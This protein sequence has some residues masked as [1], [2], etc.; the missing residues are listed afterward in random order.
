MR[1]V[2]WRTRYYEPQLGIFSALD[3]FEGKSCTPMS[4]NG[5]GYVHCNPINMVDP[6]GAIALN[7]DMSG[8]SRLIQ[9]MT[10]AMK[11]ALTLPFNPLIIKNIN[12]GWCNG[13]GKAGAGTRSLSSREM[14]T[15]YRRGGSDIQQDNNSN[16]TSNYPI[17]FV[18]PEEHSALP[19]WI[20]T[21]A[22]RICD[23]LCNRGHD[24]NIFQHMNGH[25]QQESE[26][27]CD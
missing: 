1:V 12:S 22:R 20:K 5:Y 2:F 23:E 24:D 15:F 3:P 11:S 10:Q 26:S 8:T 18:F 4:L 6:S 16:T 14:P 13:G 7:I 19:D 17:P 27:I 21:Q 9:Q 25:C